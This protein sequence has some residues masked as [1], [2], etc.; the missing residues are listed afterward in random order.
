MTSPG[1]LV[2]C[3]YSGVVEEVG[4]NVIKFQKG[5]RIAGFV[6]GS[7]HVQHEDGAFAEYIV[8]KADLQI[9]LPDY[10]SFEKAATFG[11]ASMTVGQGLYQKMGLAWPSNPSTSGETILIYGGS[12]GMGTCGIQFAKL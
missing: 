8:A 11:V 5:D 9:R 7:N 3:D 10:L 12:G 4:K 1:A 2:G 6:H